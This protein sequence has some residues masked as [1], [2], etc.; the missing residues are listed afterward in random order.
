VEFRQTCWG[1]PLQ[2][3]MRSQARCMAIH[4]LVFGETSDRWCCLI[5]RRCFGM[6]TRCHSQGTASG[7]KPPGAGG[8]TSAHR[9]PGDGRI[10]NWGSFPV[11]WLITLPA[12][13]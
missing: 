6:V 12:T 9:I 3:R 2:R 10:R 13:C 8:R 1:S 7:T 5:L 4:T 11:A